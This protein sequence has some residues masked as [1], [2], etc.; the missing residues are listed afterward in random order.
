MNKAMRKI[1]AGAALAAAAVV[2]GCCRQCE[3]GEVKLAEGG[4][5]L[6]DIVIA[7]KASV[8]AQFGALDLKWHLRK[9]TG[10][11]FRIIRDTEPQTRYE[12]RVGESRRTAHKAAEFKLQK[13]LVDVGADAIELIGWD[14]VQKEYKEVTLE[15]PDDAA[16]SGKN[17]PTTYT[18]QGS[19]YAVYEFLDRMCGVKWANLTRYGTY[20]PSKPTLA[21]AKGR[22]EGEPF[23]IYRGGTMDAANG[24]AYDISPMWFYTP[25]CSNYVAWCN[26][27]FPGGPKDMKTYDNLWL[28]RNRAG[29]E[30][31]PACHSFGWL[32]ERYW[33]E[34]SKRF[35]TKREDFF[36]KG[37]PDR[38]P[39]PCFSNPD[40]IKVVIDEAR[41]YFDRGGGQWGENA[42]CLEPEDN[43]SFCKCPNCAKDF[44]LDR[45]SDSSAHSTYWFKFVNTVAKEVKKT[46]PDKMITTLA[47]MTHEGLP[48]NIT[49]EDNVVVYSCLSCNRECAGSKGYAK[50]V[51]RMRE[52]HEKQPQ[53]RLALWL[54]N[55][56][57][58]LSAFWGN[59]HCFPAFFAHEAARQYKEFKELDARGGV[60]HCGFNG[61]VA[62]YMQLKLMVDPTREADELLDE[63][64]T[65]YGKA[66]PA[67]REFYDIVEKRFNDPKCH[68][69]GGASGQLVSWG[70]LGTPDVM[71]KLEACM[72]RAE[73]TAETPTE[74][75]LVNLFRLDV[76]DY[77]CAGFKVFQSRATTPVPKWTAKRIAAGADGDPDKVDWTKASAATAKLYMSGSAEPSPSVNTVRMAHDGQWL[78][79][80]L[81]EQTDA[82]KLVIRPLINPYDTWEM[83]LARQCAKPYRY[84]IA[85]PDGR[86]VAYCYGEVNMRQDV[87]ATEIGPALFGGRCTADRSKGDRWTVRWALPLAKMLDQPVQPGD[88]I[89]MNAVRVVNPSLA[90]MASYGIYSI[91]SHS[92]V[93]A[94]DRLGEITLEK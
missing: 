67:M 12:I 56:F 41:A 13:F 83:L 37:Y 11:D 74:K 90:K 48:T 7:E 20:L 9:M 33:Y 66:A 62:N 85:G 55:C 17:W 35:I 58:L 26:A 31:L 3:S 60:F 34:K 72:K 49:M 44:E 32:Y 29:G 70:Y 39:Q 92:N 75:A 42:Y 93:H 61:E 43:S 30:Y 15:I 73:A 19:M 82:K 68:P 38:P 89:Y 91:V 4:Q 45:A 63:Y 84:Y 6:A 59:Y 76:W 50:Q 69:G 2:V 57:P 16:P 21:V 88:K 87:R 28:L 52:W 23:M 14:G 78:Y 25:K 77:M 27:A 10:A 80:E 40:L 86:G 65:V 81:E 64:F 24:G 53:V 5:A 71:A 18:R 54:Y 46:H 79:V 94:P 8:A 51:A 47:Y 1:L 22:Y 36:A